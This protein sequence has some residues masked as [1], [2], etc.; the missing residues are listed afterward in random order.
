MEILPSA[1]QYIV[2]SLTGPSQSAGELPLN[3]LQGFAGAARS[4]ESSPLSTN[5]LI[6]GDLLKNQS[7]SEV[8]LNV[9]QGFAAAGLIAN[10]GTLLQGSSVTGQIVNTFA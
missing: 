8:P 6:V 2:S 1:N 4:T 3:V 7:A 9:L 5:H 10:A